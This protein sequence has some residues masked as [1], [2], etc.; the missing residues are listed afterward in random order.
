MLRRLI[1]IA[2][3]AGIFV[4]SLGAISA[5]DANADGQQ[6]RTLVGSWIV[7]ITSDAF[8]TFLNLGTITR[9]G[10]IIN[11]DPVFGSGHG[12]WK[13]VGRG[14]F[15]VKFLGLVPPDNPDFPP[16]TSLTVSGVVTV[17][18][19]GASASGPF[20]TVFENPAIG[21]VFRFGGTVDFDRITLGR[22][23][24]DD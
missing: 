12:V 6:G 4:I 13:R 23:D 14:R 16:G 15:A 17:S 3:L 18:N 10:S 19:D 9:D 21:E 7:T 22:T 8:P 5:N 2:A 24:H 1:L 20:E 11:S